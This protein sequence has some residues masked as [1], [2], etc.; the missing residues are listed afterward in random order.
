M[1]DCALGLSRPSSVR[2]CYFL[3]S[4]R[5][6]FARGVD[7]AVMQTGRILRGLTFVETSQL[8]ASPDSQSRPGDEVLGRAGILDI[9]DRLVSKCS[10]VQQQRLRFAMAL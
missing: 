2:G 10:G 8:T 4:P 1:I 3:M 7:S 9:S 6:R 5:A